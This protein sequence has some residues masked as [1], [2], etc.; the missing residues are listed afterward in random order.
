MKFQILIDDNFCNYS[1]DGELT[2]IDNKKILS[3]INDFEDGK[4]RYKKFQEFIWDNVKETALSIKERNALINDEGSTLGKAVEKLRLIDDPNDKDNGKGGE[5]AEIIL[6]GIMK[7]HFKAIPVVPKIFYKQNKN[8]FAKGADSVH[9]VIENNNTFSLWFGEAKFYDS[10]INSKLD[11]IVQSV[12]E[13]LLLEKLKKENSLITN[14]S[15]LK[16]FTE[17]NDELKERIIKT[18][19]EDTSIDEVKP[20]LN[21]PILMVHECKITQKETDNNPKYKNDIITFHKDRATEYFK[22]QIAKCSTVHK[23]SEIKFHII[24]FPVPYKKQ[25][26]E[27]FLAI[28]NALK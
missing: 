5:I 9:I 23:Y 10:I 25:I 12:N 1:T 6:Y 16:D 18:L 19:H 4:W 28:A 3:I 22:K 7:H 24:L 15:D 13:S 20:I 17:I 27:K 8:D 21:I 14:I 11:K 26:E 2:G